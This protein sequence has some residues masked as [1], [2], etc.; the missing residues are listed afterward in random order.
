MLNTLLVS[1]FW[2]KIKQGGLYSDEQLLPS[3]RGTIA[4]LTNESLYVG[5]EDNYRHANWQN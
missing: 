3:P 4:T 5:A 2:S 1:L